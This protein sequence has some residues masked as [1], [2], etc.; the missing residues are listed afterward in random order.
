VDCYH[1]LV[2]LQLHIYVRG[3]IMELPKEKALEFIVSHTQ[4]EILNSQD[5]IV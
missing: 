3:Y 5:K 1:L 4:Y 2:A